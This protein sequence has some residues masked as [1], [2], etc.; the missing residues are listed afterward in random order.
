METLTLI[1]SSV[2]W[3]FAGFVN[4]ITSFGGNM[5]AVPLLSLVIDPR[6]AIIFACLTGTGITVS[7]ALLYRSALPKLEFALVCLSCG[8]GVIPGMWILKVASARHLLFL[9]GIILTV[10]LLW[11]FLGRRLNSEKRIPIWAVVPMGVLSG[12]LL[13]STSM[14]GPVMAMYAVLR[15]WTKEE[16]IATLNTMAG[17]SMLF[18]MY[19]QW[20]DGLYSPAILEGATWGLPC[21]ILGVLLSVP[22]LRRV[23]AQL[24]RKGLLAMLAFSAVMLFYRSLA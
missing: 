19:L 23:N 12:I 6:D 7:L 4:G 8:A 15:R 10:F 21:C 1:Y 3:L 9:A 18:L 11:Q 17:L 22:V 20:R 5:V 24:F 2:V 16:T 13:G 14:G